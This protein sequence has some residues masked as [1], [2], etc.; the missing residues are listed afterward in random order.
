[1]VVDIKGESGDEIY[2]L[3]MNNGY[4]EFLLLNNLEDHPDLEM[5]FNKGGEERPG[6]SEEPGD[7]DGEKADDGQYFEEFSATDLL[8]GA[9]GDGGEAKAFTIADHEGATTSYNDDEEFVRRRG[10]TNEASD[11]G[12]EDGAKQK[13]EMRGGYVSCQL[14]KNTISASRFSNLSNHARRHAAIKKYKCLHCDVQLNELSKMRTHLS[15][16]HSDE[17]SDPIDNTTPET[18]QVWDY[19]VKKCFPNCFSSFCQQPAP[20]PPPPPPEEE[21][22]QQPNTDGGDVTF[23]CGKCGF[24]GTDPNEVRDHL[25]TEHEV[26]QS[27]TP[28]AASEDRSKAENGKLNGKK[29]TKSLTTDGSAEVTEEV[30]NELLAIVKANL[31]ATS[32]LGSLLCSLCERVINGKELISV[33]LHAKAHYHI[34]QFECDKCGFGS[35]TESLVRKHIYAQHRRGYT[36]V[37]EHNDEHVRKAWAQVVRT[38]FPNLPKILAR[39]NERLAESILKTEK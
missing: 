6:S 10:G 29:A 22:E 25:M 37:I 34:K 17:V 3:L 16:W 1:M 39:R 14:C 26:R 9:A 19:L 7:G 5:T 27:G 15:G 24:Q 13:I 11:G 38:C 20:P 12:V 33:V 31:A 21:E 4:N 30:S 18:Q 8:G 2:D 35:N 32:E 23:V 36:A 28:N